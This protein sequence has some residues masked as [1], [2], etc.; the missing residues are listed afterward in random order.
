[1]SSL[2]RSMSMVLEEFYEHMRSVGVSAVTGAGMPALF[3]AIHDAVDEYYAEYLPIVNHQKDK[4][5]RAIIKHAMMA[6]GCRRECG[7]VSL[8]CTLSET[9][10]RVPRRQ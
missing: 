7:A 1:M 3:D 10:N 9:D 4:K 8:D 5:V 6:C 2:T